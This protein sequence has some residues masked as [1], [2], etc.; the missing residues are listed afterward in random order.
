MLLGQLRK[1]KSNRPLNPKPIGL[2]RILFLVLQKDGRERFAG[3][4]LRL[5]LHHIRTLTYH[6]TVPFADDSAEDEERNTDCVFCTARFS[7]DHNVEEWM[8]CAKYFRWAHTLCVGM[9]E[10]FVCEPYQG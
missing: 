10:D 2:R 1:R 9:E 4:Q 7:E 3:I 6:V 5:T 8:R